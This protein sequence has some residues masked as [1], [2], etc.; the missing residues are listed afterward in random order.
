VVRCQR[1][2]PIRWLNRT[3]NL[4]IWWSD[5]PDAWEANVRIRPLG[6]ETERDIIRL[7]RTRD[8]FWSLTYVDKALP[9]ARGQQGPPQ[10]D[11]L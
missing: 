10:S 8:D 2:L 11:G 1:M 4:L 5:S 3:T 7:I 6:W 9:L